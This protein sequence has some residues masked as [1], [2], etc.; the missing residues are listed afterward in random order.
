MQQQTIPVTTFASVFKTQHAKVENLTVE[1]LLEK[2]GKM[3]H[4]ALPNKDKAPVFMMAKLDG[5]GRK[6]QNIET[7]HAIVLD[8]DVHHEEKVIEQ[9]ADQLNPFAYII[10]T[11]YSHTD[12]DSRYRVVV[13]LKHPVSPEKFEKESYAFRLATLL[14]LTVDSCSA[15]ATQCYYVPSRPVDAAPEDH[16]IVV[17]T[18]TALFDAK[19]LPAKTARPASNGSQQ[20]DKEESVIPASYTAV[21][22]LVET[23]FGGIA[24]IFAD[25]KFHIYDKGL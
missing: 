1:E 4:L 22:Q 24:P 17:G 11:T 3:Q 7:V 5:L 8:L 18:S 10:Y 6:K 14:N 23:Y 16:A 15:L 12:V 21:E 9:A 20:S 13:P 19:N 25:G 2:F